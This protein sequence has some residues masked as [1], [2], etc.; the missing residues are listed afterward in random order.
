V[1]RFPLDD[2]RELF[3]Q[4]Q[5]ADWRIATH[6]IGDVAIEQVLTL[7]ERLTPSAADRA[8]RIEHLGIPTMAHLQ[9]AASLNV[10][11][12]TQSIFLREL[13]TN[14]LHVLPD[15][16]LPQLYPFRSMLDSGMT[17]ALSSDAPVVEQDSP[18][19]GMHAAITRRTS[20][21]R[22]LSPEQALTAEQALA[23]YTLAGAT[24]AGQ[25]KV[26]GSISVGK[27]ADFV[28]LSADPVKIPTEDLLQVSIV[29]TMVNGKIVYQQQ[30]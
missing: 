16:L 22:Q 25:G 14:F 6:A 21:G 4:A 24:L 26:R 17:M 28:L 20:D 1:L 15:A 5:E 18:L 8:H 11:T 23:A 9:R 3:E 12:A 13:G 30:S 19:A 29:F 2:L 7:I 27:V 10:M